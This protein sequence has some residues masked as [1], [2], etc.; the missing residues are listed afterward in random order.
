M[1][2]INKVKFGDKVLVD[3]TADTVTA[4]DVAKGKTFHD[5]SGALKTGT[6]EE[7][8]LDRYPV[9]RVYASFDP[10]SPVDLFGGKWEKLSGVLRAANDTKTGGSDNVD[11]EYGHSY[12][13]YC[14]ANVNFTQSDGIF[15]AYRMVGNTGWEIPKWE[16]MPRMQEPDGFAVNNGL[17][18]G[19]TAKIQEILCCKTSHIIKTIDNL[20]AYQNLNV[21]RRLPDEIL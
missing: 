15:G 1:P 9:G 20:P 14:G 7:K 6:Y 12:G 11:F 16:D 17:G 18:N 5:K 4:A 10:T 2:D 21:W 8:P 13:E 19:W 3:L